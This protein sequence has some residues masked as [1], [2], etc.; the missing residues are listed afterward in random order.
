MSLQDHV[1]GDSRAKP[2]RDARGRYLANQSGNPYGARISRQQVLDQLAELAVTYDP[3]G[4]LPSVDKS[5]LELAA[6]H[7]IIA[8]RARN[9]TISVRSANMAERLLS[10]I[11]RPIA[12]PKPVSVDELLRGAR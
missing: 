8:K 12:E 3:D 10:K 1:A 4:R 6:K 9:V 5:R 2:R 11:V 7:L